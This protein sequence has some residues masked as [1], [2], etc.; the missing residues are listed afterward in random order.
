MQGGYHRP[1]IP[2]IRVSSPA[3]GRSLT[4][5]SSQTLGHLSSLGAALP[6]LWGCA[7]AVGDLVDLLQGPWDLWTARVAL[8]A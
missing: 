8:A 5:N 2:H 4:G 7:G 3:V 1:C 6:V